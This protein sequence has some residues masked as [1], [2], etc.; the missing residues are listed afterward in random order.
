LAPA[1]RRELHL[2]Q[3]IAAQLAVFVRVQFHHPVCKR[4]GIAKRTAAPFTPAAAAPEPASTESA[5]AKSAAAR[6][7]GSCH[8]SQGNACSKGQ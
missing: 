5:A 3:F 6:G 2:Q 8:G 7:L 4:S 1:E